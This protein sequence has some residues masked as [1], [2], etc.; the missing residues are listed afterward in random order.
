MRTERI[1][2]GTP[3]TGQFIAERAE[4]W[5]D[6]RISPEELIRRDPLDIGEVVAAAEQP[7]LADYVL[8]SLPEIRLP[9][10]LWEIRYRWPKDDE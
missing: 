2:I 10:H 3:D 6:P 1:R 4:L 8:Q 9:A 5:N 7:E